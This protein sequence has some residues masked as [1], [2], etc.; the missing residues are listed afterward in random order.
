[1]LA[2]IPGL[3]L[4]AR[5]VPPGTREPA[6][7]VEPPRY[8]EPLATAGLAARGM[9]GGI[10]GGAIALLL[11]AVLL[12]ADSVGEGTTLDLPG[13]MARLVPPDS[14][15]TGSMLLGALVVGAAFGLLTAAV[16]AARHGAAIDVAD[17]ES[18]EP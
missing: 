10:L 15:V 13:A 8:R 4:L 6:F 2:G 14:I 9:L 17:E 16:C 1:M 12:A 5:F 18:P 3:L 7:T 11:A